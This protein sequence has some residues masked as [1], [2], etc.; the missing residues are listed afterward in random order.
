MRAADE[1]LVLDGEWFAGFDPHAFRHA[2][3]TVGQDQP[4]VIGARRHAGHLET[5]VVVD[6][7][8]GIVGAL[9]RAEGRGAGG[10]ELK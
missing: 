10:R 9:G 6:G 7:P 3:S 4:R 2:Y 8:V 5:L 1:I